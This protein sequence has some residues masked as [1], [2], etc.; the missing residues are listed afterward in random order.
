MENVGCLIVTLSYCT[1]C[2]SW[3][4]NNLISLDYFTIIIHLLIQHPHGQLLVQ[5][6]YTNMMVLL[7]FQYG[8]RK[9]TLTNKM[10]NITYYKCT[11]FKDVPKTCM[12]VLRSSLQFQSVLCGPRVVRQFHSGVLCTGISI[13]EH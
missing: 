5:C 3:M 1:A 6:L 12:C 8:W 9:S 10:I 11:F 7:N 13:T 4:L 2:N